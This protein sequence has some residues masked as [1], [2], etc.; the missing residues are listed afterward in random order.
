[1]SYSINT[2]MILIYYSYRNQDGAT[3]E[4]VYKETT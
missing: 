2:D 3:L 1:M 4:L